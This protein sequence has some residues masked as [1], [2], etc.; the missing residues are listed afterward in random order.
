MIVECPDCKTTYR[1][2]EKLITGEGVWV[3]CSRCGR[4]FFLE[5]PTPAVEEISLDDIRA[6]LSENNIHAGSEDIE[7]LARLLEEVGIGDD[8]GGSV[9]D[10]T[11][12]MHPETVVPVA[13]EKVAQPV[14][15][16]RD[17]RSGRRVGFVLSLIA[18]VLLVLVLMGGV[19][20]WLLPD[21][22]EDVLSRVRLPSYLSSL[23]MPQKG[24]ASVADAL[25]N[26]DFT[27]IRERYVQNWIIG[28]ILVVEG[29]AQN[30]NSGLVS[31]ISVRG[32]LLDRD[33]AVL[34]EE[35]SYCGN[36]LSEDELTNL[37]REET[38]GELMRPEGSTHSNRNIPA[39]ESIPFMLVFPA[40][41]MEVS[42]IALELA[43]VEAGD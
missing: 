42:E 3:R 4:V 14:V 35:H 7:D 33:G 41:A 22:R 15:F 5:P 34:A 17:Q 19:S 30:N 28:T 21:L 40:P 27:D 39:G 36:I 38:F 1:F 11:E 13:E 18:G 26:I 9:V 37:T 6:E 25:V 2:D 31:E 8:S 16:R 10:E 23:L 43:G 29:S 32:K 12:E 20:L 24:T